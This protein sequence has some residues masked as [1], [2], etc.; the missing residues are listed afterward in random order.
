VVDDIGTV[1]NPLLAQGQIHGGV[2]QGA[3]QALLEDI[4]YDPDSGQLVTG[5]LM[6]YAVPR[7]DVLP[8]LTVGFSPVPSASN[9]IG[10]KGVGEGGTVAATPTAMNAVIDALAPLG[11]TDVAMPATPERVWRAIQRKSG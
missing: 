7:A 11:D 6:D 9:P 1:I 2:A 5:S 4:V 10:V 3:G 8:D